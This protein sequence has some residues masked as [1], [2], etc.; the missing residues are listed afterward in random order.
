MHL[1]E[2]LKFLFERDGN[3]SESCRRLGLNRQQVAKY[4][5]GEVE[6][7]VRILRTIC[8]HFGV[9]MDIAIAPLADIEARHVGPT[10][11][12]QKTDHNLFYKNEAKAN[13]RMPDGFYISWKP[14][15]L[16]EGKVVRNLAFFSTFEGDTFFRL[17]SF[18]AGKKRSPAIDS[19][20]GRVF[21]EGNSLHITAIRRAGEQAISTYD[22]RRSEGVFDE[23]LSGFVLAP[24]F[25]SDDRKRCSR[26]A[27][28]PVENPRLSELKTVPE[29][30][31]FE[32]VPAR[33]SDLLL[34]HKTPEHFLW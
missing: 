7:S 29:A 5:A 23:A 19:C 1:Q 25:N 13:I 12:H 24:A 17:M 4:L 34:L 28:E 15:F 26:V 21:A 31:L 16:V 8:E 22:L 18:G 20:V 30:V 27:L 10:L 3:I 9:S 6:P 14:S 11:L 2:N 33:I 32:D